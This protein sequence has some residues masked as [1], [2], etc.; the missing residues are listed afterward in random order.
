MKTSIIC[1]IAFTAASCASIDEKRL[2]T[3]LATAHIGESGYA[4]NER[5]YGAGV[6]FKSKNVIYGATYI[7]RNSYDK[8]SIYLHAAIE[9]R[10]NKALFIAYGG[11]AASG[12]KD[13]SSVGIL[14][15]S[16]ISIRYHNIRIATTA[17]SSAL[18]CK[19]GIKCADVIS[20]HAVF[21][22]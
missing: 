9:K 12:Y 1:L 4:Y 7:D 17:P 11:A 13:V 10:I 18:F 22:F 21:K 20:I 3:P 8:K 16:I 19:S 5:N 14:P 2:I 6:E 15:S